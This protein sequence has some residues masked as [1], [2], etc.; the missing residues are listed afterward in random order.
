MQNTG[1]AEMSAPAEYLTIVLKGLARHPEKVRIVEEVDNMGRLL[2]VYVAEDD[3]GIMIGKAGVNA[4]AIKLLMKM[5]GFVHGGER[6]SMKI[7]EP[8]EGRREYRD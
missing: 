4:N 6:I 5:H 3:M 8:E 2:K 7:M 1:T